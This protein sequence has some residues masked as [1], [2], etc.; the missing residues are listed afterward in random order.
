MILTVLIPTMFLIA[1]NDYSFEVDQKG[2]GT[3]HVIL[4]P[5]FSC[6]AAVWDE[7]VALLAPKYNCHA[8]TFAGFA[9]HEAGE[10]AKLENWIDEIATYIDSEIDG[11]VHIVGHSIGGMMAQWLAADH[12]GLVKSIVVVDAL[13]SL[14][15]LYNPQFDPETGTDCSFYNAMFDA[16]DEDFEANQRKG[17]V[18]QSSNTEKHEQIIDWSVS[19]DRNTLREIFC[20]IMNVDLREKIAKV[21]CESLILLEANFKL[22]GSSI[23]DQYNNLPEAKINFANKG[24]H[25]IMYDDWDWYKDQIT[26]H[27]N[28]DS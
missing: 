10:Q 7:T 20:Q 4:I 24:M 12:P 5:G 21:N 9:G 18:M 16:S 27:F 28:L 15:S 3:E 11:K 25:F 8:L 22:M 23:T 6:G 2:Q 26:A 19:S 17:L 1:G 13:P 14:A